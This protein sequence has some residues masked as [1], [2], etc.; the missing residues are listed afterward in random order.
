MAGYSLLYYTAYRLSDGWMMID[1]FS[2]CEDTV[3][4]Y[5]KSLKQ[6]IDDYYENPEDW[7]EEINS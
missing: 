2:D 5:M 4:D 7:E 6:N 1:S 3:R